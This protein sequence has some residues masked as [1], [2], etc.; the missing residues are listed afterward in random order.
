MEYAKDEVFGIKYNGVTD[1]SKFVSGRYKYG[2]FNK[3]KRHKFISVIL[4]TT[5][6]LSILNIFM[7]YHFMKTLQNI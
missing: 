6:I 1:T 3:I 7:V 4:S 5:L 2:I